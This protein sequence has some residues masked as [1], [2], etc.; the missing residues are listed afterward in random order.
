MFCCIG[1]VGKQWLV[2]P[3]IWWHKPGE[4]RGEIF[5]WNKRY[6]WMAGY[7]N[8]YSVMFL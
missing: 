3:P 8:I 1:C 5:Y 2:L 6:G 7:A 4:G